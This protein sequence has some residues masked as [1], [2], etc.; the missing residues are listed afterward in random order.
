MYID[1]FT[2]VAPFGSLPVSHMAPFASL[3]VSHMTPTTLS[4]LQT[5]LK[6]IFKR[7]P[8][9]KQKTPT[10]SALEQSILVI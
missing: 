8:G 4:T 3:P 2:K 5:A 10:I 9:Y 7:K 1:F 6:C